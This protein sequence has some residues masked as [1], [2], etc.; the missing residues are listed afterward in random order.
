MTDRSSFRP[1]LSIFGVR[2]IDPGWIY[3]IKSA[4]LLKVGKTKNLERRIREA[5]TWIPDL[6]IIGVKP[7]WEISYIERTL[8]IGLAQNWH[9]G[10]W[11][12]FSE[13]LDYELIT[14]G[15]RE[16]YDKDKDMNSVDFIYW[17]NDIGLGDIAAEWGSRGISPRQWK[18]DAAVEYKQT[19]HQAALGFKRRRSKVSHAKSKN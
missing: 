5:K 15:F 19:I 3:L 9:A 1:N 7:F 17:Y 4:E 8:Q 16:F 18:R 6:E 13:K 2:R 12:S 10:E 11:F 14:E